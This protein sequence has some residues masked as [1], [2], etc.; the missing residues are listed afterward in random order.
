MRIIHNRV[1]LWETFRLRVD[2][3]LISKI[4][5]LENVSLVFKKISHFL[6]IFFLC[7]IIF[8]L[9][10]RILYSRDTLYNIPQWNFNSRHLAI[11]KINDTWET[12]C[13]IIKLLQ[14]ILITL[15]DVI[16][17]RCIIVIQMNIRLTQYLFIPQAWC[18]KAFIVAVD[19]A[20]P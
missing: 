15:L 10:I 13:T 7:R 1:R 6:F 16:E 2:N 17:R 11:I 4:D 3:L 19:R 8:S 5:L 12:S 20:V 9:F 14:R 18:R